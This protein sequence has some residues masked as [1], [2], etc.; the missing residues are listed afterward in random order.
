MN[1]LGLI[2]LG[3]CA[4][5]LLF[6]V[7]FITVFIIVVIVMYYRFLHIQNEAKTISKTNLKVY[8]LSNRIIKY[9][10]VTI[11]TVIKALFK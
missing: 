11:D 7:D 3:L 9:V 5:V 10:T 6:V 1:N 4:L 8:N 2:I